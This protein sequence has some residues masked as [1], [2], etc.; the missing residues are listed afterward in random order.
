M[1][2]SKASMTATVISQSKVRWVIA[3]KALNANKVVGAQR[4]RP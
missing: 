3:D 1:K 2:P 4:Q